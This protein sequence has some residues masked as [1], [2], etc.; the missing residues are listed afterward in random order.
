M[1]TVHLDRM[2]LWNMFL[3]LH[4]HAKHDNIV[5]SAGEGGTKERQRNN[6]TKHSWRAAVVTRLDYRKSVFDGPPVGGGPTA[7]AAAAR[8]LTGQPR[9]ACRGRGRRRG[10]MLQVVQYRCLSY[11]SF[12]SIGNRAT[13]ALHLT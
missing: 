13:P 11:C 5:L 1:L 6:C 3:P 8:R 4:G 2:L 12:S 9:G 7:V 10:G